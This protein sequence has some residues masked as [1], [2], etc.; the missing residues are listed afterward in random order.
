VLILTK[1]LGTGVLFNANRSGKLPWRELEQILPEVAALNRAALD[2]A[3]KFDVHACTDVTGF[4][5]LGHALEMSRGS[6]V[7]IDLDFSAL[8]FYPNAMEMYRK[9]ENT[10]SNGANRRLVERFLQISL[11][12]ADHE[13]QVLFDPQTS[14]GLLVSVPEPQGESLVEQL[15]AAGVGAAALIGRV[16]GGPEPGIRLL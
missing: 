2:V 3:L 5:I 13:E 9:G 6:A 10:G 7:G 12:L 4:G 14:G 8:P 1:P 15:R 11:D 16:T